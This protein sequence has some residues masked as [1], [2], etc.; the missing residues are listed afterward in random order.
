MPVQLR[1][2]ICS[3]AASFGSAAAI[4]STMRPMTA[5]AAL[6]LVLDFSAAARGAHPLRLPLVKRITT[7]GSDEAADIRIA[8]APAQWAVVHRSDAA[9]DVSIG[10]TRKQ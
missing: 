1:D 3:V 7:I 5:A 8:T 2:P 4:G 10:G 9:V 6:L